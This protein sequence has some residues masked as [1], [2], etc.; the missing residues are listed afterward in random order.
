MI[1]VAICDGSSVFSVICVLTGY[2]WD[3]RL[4]GVLGVA[5]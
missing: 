1:A 2:W 3:S 4:A 5:G